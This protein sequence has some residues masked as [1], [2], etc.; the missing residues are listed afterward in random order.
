MRQ[1]AHKK[2]EALRLPF[3]SI[4]RFEQ[5]QGVGDAHKKGKP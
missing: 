2:G 4:F 1:P 5:A 3:L